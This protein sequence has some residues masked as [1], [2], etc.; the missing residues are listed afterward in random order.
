MTRPTAFVCA[1]LALSLV[2][3]GHADT[4]LDTF[5]RDLERTESIRAVKT[6]QSSLRAVCAVRPVERG[7]RAVHTRRQLRVRRSGQAGT[8]C[9]GGVRHRRLPAYALWRRPGGADC[10][11][12][13]LDDDRCAGASISPPDGNSAKARWQAIIFHGHG[14]QARIE[15]GVFVNDY[16]REGGVWKFA[17]AHYHP[18]YDGPYEEGWTNWGGGDLP[19][20][21][22]HF[23]TTTAGIPIPPATGVAPKTSATL[24]ALQQRVDVL[25]D[26]DRIRNLQSAYGYYAD[27]K[28]WDD[29]VDL[30]AKDGVVEIGG[31]G[32]W[33]GPAGI[34]RWLETMGPA[35]LTHGQLND[36]AAERRDRDHRA[37][38][39]RSLRA[40]HR[41][42]HA[43]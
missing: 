42:R 15:G 18:Q 32:I 37:G 39:Q 38:R 36:R 40:R 33:R 1:T 19:V 6:L 17:T 20:V 12:P 5:A 34:R 27:R 26:E 4:G 29:V 30:F 43:R 7:R 16:V 10:E 28:M 3:P 25:N 21:P 41:A 35:G 22:Y 2:L 23:D 8:D 13:L 14:E 31:Q 11:E 24:A 9:E